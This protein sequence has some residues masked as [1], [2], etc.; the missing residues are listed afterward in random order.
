MRLA[1]ATL[2]FVTF[3]QSSFRIGGGDE[4]PAEH[5]AIRVPANRARAESGTIQ[6]RY[7]RFRSSAQKPGAPIVFLAGGPGDAATRA[8]A[9]MPRAFLEML[10]ET[11]DVIAFDQRG[12]G[13][14]EP[15][16][17]CAPAAIGALEAP[18]DPARMIAV[19]RERLR[20]CLD[21]HAKAGTDV[22][23][24]TTEE[25][26]DDVE[27]L[28]AALGAERV[29]LLAG[30]YGTHL[31]LA[32]ARRH[33]KSVERMALFGVEGPDDTLKLPANV[34]GILKEIDGAHPG[35]V[36]SIRTLRARL[37]EQPWTKTLPNGQ[38]VAVGEWDLQ[39]RVSEALDS[40][41][42]ISALVSALP[43]MM[44][45]DYSDLVR[46]AIPFRAARPLNLMN[47]AMDCASFATDARLRAI[48]SQTASSVL[49]GAMNF[50]LPDLCGVDGLP[51]LSDAF[52]APLR[53]DIPTLL[54]SGT[55]DG[56]TPP[57]NAAAVAATMPRAKVVTLPKASHGLFQ[58]PAAIDALRAFLKK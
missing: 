47:V 49:G 29:S 50:P 27:A 53:G 36:E 20:A 17:V 18:S 40:T 39:R 35:F 31:A 21:A 16:A 5:G 30:S 37:R 19:Q 34:D 33:P 22:K 38:T 42:E 41:R 6:L 4:M 54:V 56:R 8:F 48:T 12:T 26:A 55:W 15:R 10:L 9:G 44:G 2:L 23:G 24:L 13:T 1:A 14:S 11:A 43:V 3:A 57:A 28:R 46:W 32:V 25:S 52:R 51:R 45:G 7:V 58:E